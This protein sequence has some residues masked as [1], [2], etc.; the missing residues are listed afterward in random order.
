ME[1]E[2]TTLENLKR[3]DN[4]RLADEYLFITGGSFG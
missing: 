3:C 2:V 4:M 1:L